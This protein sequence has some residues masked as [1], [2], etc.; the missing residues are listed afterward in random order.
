M[1]Y[2]FIENSFNFTSSSLNLKAIDAAQKILINFVTELNKKGHNVT[3]YNNIKKNVK[4]NGIY[5]K[6]LSCLE[7]DNLDTDILIVCNE[8]S[9]IDLKVRASIKLYWLT[10]IIQEDQK[11]SILIKLLKNKFII[12][13]SSYS[14]ISYLPKTYNYIPKIF[15]DIGV[16]DL[17][18]QNNK[19]DVASCKAL[20][21]AHPLRGLDWLIEIWVNIISLKLPWAEMHVYSQTLSKNKFIKNTKINNLKLKIIKY[22]NN[23]IHVIKPLAEPEF[24]KNLINYKVHLNPSNNNSSLSVL[25]SQAAG[26]PVV[27]RKNSEIQ[28]YIY[29][30]ETGFIADDANIFSKKV[31]DLLSDNSTFL[32]FRSNSK[33][34]N[35]IKPWKEVIEKLETKIH[36]NFINR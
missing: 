35:R 32:R 6:K 14:L 2:I 13:H 31:I 27:S 18:F 24:L 25:E 26:I 8:E 36:E 5:W 21:T 15:F 20:V 4:E 16:S 3:V 29:H 23:G 7:K 19:Y 9:F 22:K 12:I 33:L 17:F 30:N 34:N 1:K 28:N 10:S 11:N